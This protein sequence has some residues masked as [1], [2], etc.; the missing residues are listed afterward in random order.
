[1][2]IISSFSNAQVRDGSETYVE[3]SQKQRGY[4][5]RLLPRTPRSFE[6]VSSKLLGF[7]RFFG[8]SLVEVWSKFFR[9]LF[10]VCSKFDRSS[11]DLWSKFGRY[12]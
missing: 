10:E 6:E 2:E 5:V 1:M 3:N 8:R 4:I 12:F 7:F 11:F 9:S